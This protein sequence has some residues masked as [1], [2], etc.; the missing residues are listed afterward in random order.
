MRPLVCKYGF[1]HVIGK[2]VHF[3]MHWSLSLES[4]HSFT[5]KS[6]NVI[7]MKLNIQVFVFV[8]VYELLYTYYTYIVYFVYICPNIKLYIGCIMYV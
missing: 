1:M 2:E 3:I 8:R 5:H 4:F 7:C 6:L